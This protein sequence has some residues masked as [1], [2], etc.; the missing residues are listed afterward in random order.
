MKTCAKCTR[1]LPR[2]AFG[3]CA[4]TRTGLQSYC[5][6]C[7]GRWVAENRPKRRAQQRAWYE[8]NRQAQA[9]R[10]RANKYGITVD[11]LQRLLA[12]RNCEA[13]GA[14]LDHD[15]HSHRTHVDHCHATGKVRGVLC[16]Y[17]NVAIGQIGDSPERAEQLAAYLRAR[18]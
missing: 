5:R 10:S 3:K 12:V 11:E 4:R 2:E 18:A 8:R 6:E 15:P 14:E 9:L 13:C 1:D 17:C 7:Q 16:R